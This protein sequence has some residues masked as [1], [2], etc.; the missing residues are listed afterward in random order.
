MKTIAP[1][2]IFSYDG[3]MHHVFHASAGEGLSRHE[4][5]FA[6]ATICHAGACVIRKESVERRITPSDGAFDLPANKWHEIE[7]VADGTV[8][9]NIFSKEKVK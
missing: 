5:P 8:F 4:H 1:K 6:H 3:V 7:A 2:H 9:E